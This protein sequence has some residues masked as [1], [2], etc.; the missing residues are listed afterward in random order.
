MIAVGPSDARYPA[1][2]RALEHPP[3]PLWIDGDTAALAARAVAIVGTRRMTTYGERVARELAGACASEGVVVVSGLAQG[4]DSA[5]HRGALDGGGR[6]VAVLGEGIVLFLATVRGRRRPLVPRIR[7]NGALVSQYAPS[8]CAQPWMFARRNATIWLRRIGRDERAHRVW[9]RAS[10]ARRASGLGGAW[11]RRSGRRRAAH[12]SDPRSALRR[13][14][15]R[16]CPATTRAHD[17][18]RARPAAA[19]AHARRSGHED[20]GWTLLRCTRSGHTKQMSAAKRARLSGRVVIP[21]RDTGRGRWME[22][23]A[24]GVGWA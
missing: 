8:F 22:S 19:A 10:F 14:A 13:S 11:R 23:H 17:G 3:D 16:R 6:T 1:R 4:I 12:R 20:T 9:R 24:G 5:A 21:R 15:G 2:L 7:A 18:G